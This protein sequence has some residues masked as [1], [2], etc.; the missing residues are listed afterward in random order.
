MA[1]TEK[2]IPDLGGR[3]AVVTGANG[4]LGFQTALALGIAV[5][6]DRLT[7]SIFVRGILVLPWLILWIGP[8]EWGL[9]IFLQTISLYVGLELHRAM[10]VA[11]AA[12]GGQV[13]LTAAT[14]KLLREGDLGGS[15]IADDEVLRHLGHALGE[16]HHL[17]VL[18]PAARLLRLPRPV[19]PAA[20]AVRHA[21]LGGPGRAGG[22]GRGSRGRRLHSTIAAV[23]R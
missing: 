10:R 6:M 19:A 4:G 2:D 16:R 18:G 9:F 21:R 20:R 8:G 23:P 12:P 13:V 7:Q 11:E 1:W 17:D 15:V 14:Q 5:L 3:T 22:Q